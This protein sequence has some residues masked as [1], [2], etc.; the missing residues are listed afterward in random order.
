MLLASTT[1]LGINALYTSTVTSFGV[2]QPFIQYGIIQLLGPVV[3]GVP[4]VVLPVPYTDS[5]YCIQLTYSNHT[6]SLVPIRQFMYAVDATRSNF[7]VFGTQGK[8]VY[9]TTFGDVF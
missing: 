9:W 7:S 1:T 3:P 4:N 2:R 8:Y 6:D 5:N